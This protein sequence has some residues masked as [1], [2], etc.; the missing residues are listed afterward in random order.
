MSA[1]HPSSFEDFSAA[2]EW[3]EQE[4]EQ[5]QEQKPAQEQPEASHVGS[6]E[7]GFVWESNLDAIN[8]AEMRTRES[9]EAL[10]WPEEKNE[11]FSLAVREAV[12]NAVIHGNLDI[13]RNDGETL[14]AYDERRDVAMRSEGGKKKVNVEI[15]AKERE[16]RV[17]VTDEGNFV[18]ELRPVS[19]VEG[20]DDERTMMPSGRGL[21]IILNGCDAVESA[22]GQ[23]TLI[24]YRDG[25]PKEVNGEGGDD[26]D[27]YEEE[28]TSHR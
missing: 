5:E 23:L 26:E 24:K 3:P 8:E 14:A 25:K 2:S 17:V 13:R 10:H 6:F 21:E 7:R 11:E 18:A 1:E 22:P 16:I 12:T 20:N 9:C 19:D 15:Y 28:N 27:D 4:Q